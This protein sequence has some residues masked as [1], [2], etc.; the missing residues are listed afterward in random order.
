MM[1]NH[2]R[3]GGLGTWEKFYFFQRVEC[4]DHRTLQFAGP[5]K[6][7]ATRPS[8][9]NPSILKTFVAMILL[10][11]RDWFYA[12]PIFCQGPQVRHFSDTDRGKAKYATAMQKA[13][14][15]VVTPTNGTYNATPLDYSLCNFDHTTLC[16]GRNSC[17]L[18]AGTVSTNHKFKAK[19]VDITGPKFI[20]DALT[21][22]VAAY[23]ALDTL[24]GIVIPTVCGYFD[25]WGRLHL[26]ALEDVGD[27]VDTLYPDGAT[28]N[29]AKDR[30]QYDEH[31][32]PT[33][34]H[35]LSA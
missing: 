24:Q 12:S 10:S 20:V 35:W 2:G 4:A 32:Q 1:F 25:V 5:I 3:Y 19:V 15:F 31:P 22:E 11:N 18:D 23:A 30:H 16:C 29:T 13:G 6:L 7:L 17:I 14:S 8:H 9:K 26:L 27:N 28:Y 34:L 33:T 21:H